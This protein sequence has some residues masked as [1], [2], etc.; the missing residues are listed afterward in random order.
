MTFYRVKEKFDNTYIFKTDWT[1]IGGELLTESEVEHYKVPIH[2]LEPV[3]YKKNQV[4]WSFGCR[5][6]YSWTRED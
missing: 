5:F 3:E 2:W 4:Y 1:A 6:P